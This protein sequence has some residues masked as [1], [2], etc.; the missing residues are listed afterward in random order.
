M[1]IN[2]DL[3]IHI[4]LFPNLSDIVS[5]INRYKIYTIAVT[6]HPRVFEK[7]QSG[8]SSQY[9]RIALG[10]HPELVCQYK[11]H[12]PMVWDLLNETEY[13]GE[14]GLDFNRTPDEKIII[15]KTFFKEL[16]YKCNNL[17]GKIVSL[18]SRYA[19]KEVLDTLVLFDNNTYVLHWFCG[20]TSQMRIAV[21]L[22][23]YFSINYSM[24]SSPRLIHMIKAIPLNRLLI[25]S[26]GPFI[27]VEGKQ[28]DPS[29]HHLIVRKLASILSIDYQECIHILSSNFRSLL[30][31]HSKLNEA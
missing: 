14:V 2:H 25:E 1:P 8:V 26:D 21:S 10:L 18:H 16:L 23:C 6:N 4:D 17:G 11:Q 31:N 5:E 22:G 20:S 15:Q 12:I 9:I 3:H 29:L 30:I 27:P 13:I 24:L 7:L 28:Y 19:I